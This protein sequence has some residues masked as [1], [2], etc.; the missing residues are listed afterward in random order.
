MRIKLKA[1]L[2]LIRH[3]ETDWNAEGRF[4]GQTD[5]PLN[6]KGIAQAKGN[7]QTL[8]N[9]F[10][11]EGAPLKDWHFLA[12]PL[13]RTRNTMAL[14]REQL[15]LDPDKY[16][17]DKRLLEITFGD[18]EK[19]TLTELEHKFPDMMAE[20]T[21]DKWAY[22]PPNG[23]SYAMLCD[24]IRPV[25]EALEAPTIIVAHG[26]VIRAARTFLEDLPIKNAANTSTPQDDV[27]YA[28]ERGGYWLSG[29]NYETHA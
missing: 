14:V 27:Y 19:H 29:K 5:I 21:R 23:E 7:G 3:G 4:Q 6:A 9:H 24:R 12:S 17:T 25:F 22:Q 8:L 10:S 2:Y 13:G 1:P 28:D 11:K 26:G 20:R 15:Q 18:W 16:E